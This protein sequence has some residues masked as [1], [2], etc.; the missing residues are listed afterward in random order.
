ML[1]FEVNPVGVCLTCNKPE[2]KLSLE[3][4]DMTLMAR[5]YKLTSKSALNFE[6]ALNKNVGFY[7]YTGHHMNYLHIPKGTIEYRKILDED[8]M[9]PEKLILAIL[10]A[11]TMRGI[12]R[13]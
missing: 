13:T 10:P 4:M 11:R 3:I 12:V 8:K 2:T 6:Q 9:L 1:D 5:Y 7:S